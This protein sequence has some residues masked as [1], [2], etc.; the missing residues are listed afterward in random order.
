M[1]PPT[2]D[3]RSSASW[4][5]GRTL[6]SRGPADPFI[7][8]VELQLQQRD[9]RLMKELVFGT[10]RW[11]RRL[12]GVLEMASGRSLEAVDSPLRDPLRLSLIHISEPTRRH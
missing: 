11:L 8:Q 2:G 4:V 3:A 10:L 7:Q 9:R 6:A 12:D 1:R 5:I